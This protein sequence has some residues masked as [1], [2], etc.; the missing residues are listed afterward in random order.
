MCG[1]SPKSPCSSISILKHWSYVIAPAFVHLIIKLCILNRLLIPTKFLSKRPPE[2]AVF[3]FNHVSNIY[4]LDLQNKQRF[5]ATLVK[6][7]YI[8]IAPI[9]EQV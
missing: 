6:F 2:V 3:C 4:L 7:N 8:Y 5:T 9:L 1:K